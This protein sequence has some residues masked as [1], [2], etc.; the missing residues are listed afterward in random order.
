MRGVNLGRLVL[1][2]VTCRP[3]P[4]FKKVNF[5]PRKSKYSTMLFVCCE[6]IVVRRFVYFG[7]DTHGNG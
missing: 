4:L 5:I 7:A 6:Q 3:G 1:M 2:L